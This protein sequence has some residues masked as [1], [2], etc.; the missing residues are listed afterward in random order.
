MDVPVIGV[1]TVVKKQPTTKFMIEA[2]RIGGTSITAV[3]K[4]FLKCE[5]QLFLNLLIRSC[6]K[7]RRK[8]QLPLVLIYF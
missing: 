4:R 2:S 3:K 7:D 6:Y 8:E 1:K 5:F